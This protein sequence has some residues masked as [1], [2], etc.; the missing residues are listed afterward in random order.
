MKRQRLFRAKRLLGGVSLLVLVGGCVSTSAPVP[1][2]GAPS[3][4]SAL[5]GHWE[6]EY[7]SAANGRLGS[8]VFDGRRRPRARRRPHDPP[9]IDEAVRTR[10]AP[11][12]RVSV[13]G[14]DV[15]A[16][17]DPLRQ[18]GRVGEVHG[19]S[20]AGTFAS[21]RNAGR[22]FGTWKATRKR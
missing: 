19:D 2:E 20:V 11:G 7:S 9:R 14:R 6:G 16:P 5:A 12:G 18:G 13:A 17:H 22:V 21:S 1:V 15:P 4:I 3:E 10:D 8:I